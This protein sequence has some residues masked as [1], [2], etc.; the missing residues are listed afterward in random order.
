M[1]T[2]LELK[3]LFA[4]DAAEAIKQSALLG[5]LDRGPAHRTALH[6][7]YFDTSEGALSGAGLALRVRR[8]GDRWIQTLKGAGQAVGGLHA[9]EEHEWELRDGALDASL[10]DAGTLGNLG[11]L[12]KHFD[13]SELLPMFT[14][15]FEREACDVRLARDTVAELAIDRG[16]IRAGRRAAPISEIE[17]ELK[18]GSV[19]VL[20]DLA[21]DL[22]RELPL[23]IGY[24]SK[25]ERGFELTSRARPRALKAQ[26]AR[27]DRAMSIEAAAAVSLHACL[28][29]MQANEAGARLGLEPEFLHQFRV[30]LRRL[31]AVLSAFDKALPTEALGPIKED[32][33]WLAAAIGTA[34]DWDVWCS[35]TLPPIAAAF[36]QMNGLTALKRRSARLRRIAQASVRE[37]LSSSRYPV[38]LLSL[39]RLAAQLRNQPAA[40]NVVV[41][42]DHARAWLERRA[43]KLAKHDP[44]E[45]EPAARHAARIAGKKLRYASELFAPLFRAKRAAAYIE[46][47]A[48]LQD[49]L[50]ALNDAVVSERLLATAAATGPALP[51]ELTG[52]VRGWMAGISSIRLHELDRAWRR[53]KKAKAFW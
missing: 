18:S 51:P 13:P 19:D 31:R 8:D 7:T 25:A 27:I 23:S 35:Q 42:E 48:D 38:L 5:G 4:P 45:A 33:R 49:V 39:G 11:K 30:G 24:A 29:H 12:A 32:V 14:T 44:R 40:E 41:L 34:R 26:P 22:V 6:S 3:L 10:L 36:A 16:S 17:I 50:G 37:A 43:A 15:E 52:T 1:P 47:L 9:R 46:R 53:F 20:F 28:A 2:E 21:L